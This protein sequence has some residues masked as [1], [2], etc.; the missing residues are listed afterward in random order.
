M[1]N[2]LEKITSRRCWFVQHFMV[3]GQIG[4]GE[5]EL[6]VA[7]LSPAP[8]VLF[9]QVDI[10]DTAQLVRFDQLIDHRG[11]A[12]PSNIKVPK[13]IVR[14]RQIEQAFVVGDETS[15]SFKI[16]IDVSVTQAVATDL[17]VIEMGD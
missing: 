6:L 1:S 13:V 10:G 3:W 9:G 7:E 15:E 5:V 11:N 8:M 2:A 12:L 14:P 4:L 16:A 17:M